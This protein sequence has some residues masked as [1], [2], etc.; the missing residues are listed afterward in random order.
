M[1]NVIDIFCGCGGLSKGFEL[2]GYNIL[3]GIDNDQSALDTFKYNHPQ[4]QTIK[5]DL[6]TFNATRITEYINKKIDV[7]VG[8]PPCQGMSLAG[9]KNYEDPR[10]K[11]YLSYLNLINFLKPKAIIIENVPG[12]VT[13]YKGRIKDDIISSLTKMGYKVTYKILCSSDYGVPQ[14]RRRVFFVALK[15]NV[16]KFPISS[17]K[18]IT[19]EMAISDLPSLED[20][21]GVKE[22]I[23]QCKPKNFYQKMMRENSQKVFNHLGTNHSDRVK[24]II[25]LIPDGGNYKCLPEK[26]KKEVNFKSAWSRFS[27]NKPAPTIDTGHR[28]HFHYK[29]NRVPTVRECARLQSFPD[30]FIFIGTKT[31]QLRQ[32][33][34]AVPPLMAKSL[35]EKLLE[36]LE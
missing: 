17:S 15:N 8:G 35:A 18:L 7:I 25:S 20:N 3:L 26:Y 24:S 31:Q 30:D 1:A 12:L 14:K 32:V 22:N 28:H 23:Y 36:Y 2:A 4:A 29:F 34:N 16:F 9:L 21:L 13:L 19:C 11:L 10:N 5:A 6:S 33:G 27:S